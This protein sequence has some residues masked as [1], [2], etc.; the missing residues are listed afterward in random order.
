MLQPLLLEL[1]LGVLSPC[2]CVQGKALF[3]VINPDLMPSLKMKS[4]VSTICFKERNDL[5]VSPKSN[6]ISKNSCSKITISA[7]VAEIDSIFHDCHD[8]KLLNFYWRTLFSLYQKFV[9]LHQFIPFSF[10]L[11]LTCKSLG[12][13]RWFQIF[14]FIIVN[15]WWP[16]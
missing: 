3:P 15:N 11:S 1:A 5:H 9:L 10:C 14:F 4:K 16:L 7:Q 8:G 6:V 2:W 12:S 13:L